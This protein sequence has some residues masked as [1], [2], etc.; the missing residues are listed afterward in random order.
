MTAFSALVDDAYFWLGTN[1]ANAAF[2]RA[3]MKRLVNMAKDAFFEDCVASF[4]DALAQTYALTADST[5]TRRYIFAAQ[6]PVVGDLAKIVEVA[7][8]NAEGRVLHEAPLAERYVR[9]GLTF[10]LVGIGTSTV[11]L[12]GPGVGAGAALYL[13][14]VPVAADLSADGDQPTWL[15]ARFHDILSLRAAKLAAGSGDEQRLSP[16]LLDTL[17]DREAQARLAFSQRSLTP[18]TTRSR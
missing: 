12:T 7:V 2:P 10:A 4:P 3:T 1:D 16:L 14:A 15:P 5:D 6:T 11:L 17:A 13:A 18:T 8:T 9:G